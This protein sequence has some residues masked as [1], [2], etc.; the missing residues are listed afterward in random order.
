MTAEGQNLYNGVLKPEGEITPDGD[1]SEPKNL[2][3]Y[4]IKNGL[5]KRKA[6]KRGEQMDTMPIRREF[7]TKNRNHSLDAAPMLKSK[8]LSKIREINNIYNSNETKTMPMAV[9]NSRIN[10]YQNRQNT[11]E[12]L[13]SFLCHR[14]RIEKKLDEG[15]KIVLNDP[16]DIDLTSEQTMGL[17]DGPYSGEERTGD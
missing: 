4:L 8:P 7:G 13:N 6:R 2:Y 3:A 5:L 15:Y 1:A 9:I 17:K 16:N 10:E 12:Y 14:R 11:K